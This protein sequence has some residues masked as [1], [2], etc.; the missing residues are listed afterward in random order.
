MSRSIQNLLIGG[1]VQNTNVNVGEAQ[2]L[3]T[4]A[5]LPPTSLFASGSGVFFGEPP[6]TVANPEAQHAHRPVRT[7]RAERR[8]HAGANC[9]Q[10]DQL[11][12]LGFRP[13]RPDRPD[14]QRLRYASTDLILPRGVINAKV[15]GNISNTGNPLVDPASTGRAFFAKSV[16]LMHGPV[17]PPTVPYQPF[18]TPTKY[19]VGQNGLKGLFKIDHVPAVV[20]HQTQARRNSR[21]RHAPRSAEPA[22]S[23]K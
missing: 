18:A 23:Y 14:R 11:D 2:S 19:H 5:N 15:E 4:F 7:D 13:A 10:R 9:R 21:A 1:D 12:L 6:P 8:N 16:K 22:H 17:I 3:F 20:G